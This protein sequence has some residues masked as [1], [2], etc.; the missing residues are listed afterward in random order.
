MKKRLITFNKCKN[1]KTFNYWVQTNDDVPQV[2]FYKTLQSALRF[3]VKWCYDTKTQDGK[4]FGDMFQEQ[5]DI[6]AYQC[7]NIIDS[8]INS[9]AKQY[10]AAIYK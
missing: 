2:H 9:D 3:A 4:M 6:K 1:S 7:D 10:R 8:K 5:L